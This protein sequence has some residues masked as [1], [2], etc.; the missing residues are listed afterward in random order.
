ME[1]PPSNTNQPEKEFFTSANQPYY[2]SGPGAQ[3]QLPNESTIAT[4][5]NVSLFIS[6]PAAAIGLILGIV[7]VVMASSAM[8]TYKA[9]PTQFDPSSY[10]KV[11]GA[12]IKGIIAMC[13][14]PLILIIVFIMLALD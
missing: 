6:G 2:M 3:Q 14:I 10:K 5:G 12:L 9:S 4:L 7:T 1:T 13:V 8:R 11:K